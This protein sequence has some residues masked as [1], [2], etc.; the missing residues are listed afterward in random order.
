MD[1]S[2]S[3][4]GKYYVTKKYGIP[5]LAPVNK[6]VKFEW[7]TKHTYFSNFFERKKRDMYISHTRFSFHS[8]NSQIK[9]IMK[10]L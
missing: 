8:K 7:K 1:I 5:T 2:N 9:Y 10:S 4:V 3:G 6:L